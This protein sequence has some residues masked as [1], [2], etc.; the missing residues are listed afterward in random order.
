[1]LADM[2][3]KIPGYTI[4]RL[5]GEGGMAKVY[6]AT[7]NSLN[8]DV[9]IKVLLN[10]SDAQFAKR[11]MV[12]ARTIAALNHPRVITIYD[13]AQLDDGCFYF[14]MEYLSGG[15]L[16]CLK[17]QVIAPDRALEFIR[18]VA[19]GLALVHR[20]NI[21]HRDI[22][23]ANILFRSD[24]TLV[25]TDFGIAKNTVQ[26][27]DLTQEGSSVGSPSYSSPEQTMDKPL[28]QRTDI[29][30]MGV[31]LM[32]MLLGYNPFLGKNI[33]ETAINHLQ[34]S[35]P[36]L[37]PEI[38]QH[39]KLLNRMLAKAPGDR[40]ETVDELLKAIDEA[41]LVYGSNNKRLF[42][43]KSMASLKGC[44]LSKSSGVV[45]FLLCLVGLV[46]AFSYE[47]EADKK[48]KGFLV[49]AEQSIED[50]RFD[51]P[52]SNNAYYYF[53][54]ALIVDKD[55]KSALKGLMR[56]KEIQIAH[57][58]EG[59]QYCMEQE[60][61]SMPPNNNAIYYYNKVLV[62]APENSEAKE[63]LKRLTAQYIT[64]AE[65]AFLSKK[66]RQAFQYLR[67]GLDLEP[68]NEALAQLRE[69]YKHQSNGFKRLLNKVFK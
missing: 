49:A 5:L 43:F 24:N 54:E 62:L 17:G 63:G 19:E 58:L 9:A 53:N 32:E 52:E 64:L 48:I 57:Y 47:S 3:V 42:S 36:S 34:L 67:Q 13:V 40:F 12:E 50:A 35:I 25:L 2:P 7:Q 68:E 1:M 44:I 55:N 39:Q 31:I 29:Y 4:H 22:K 45:C 23:P 60:L 15:D 61:W 8:R 46:F 20:N 38:L 41:L 33:T 18:Q 28:D 69:Q 51:E 10:P 37:S 6:L 16:S 30:S 26:D 27:S 59:A 11:F 65:Q 21:I 66:Y 56:L 14:A